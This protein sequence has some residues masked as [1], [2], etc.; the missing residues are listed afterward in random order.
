MRQKGQHGKALFQS[1]VSTPQS[2]V[3]YLVPCPQS[4]RILYTKF[5]PPLELGKYMFWSLVPNPQ[6]LISSLV[7]SLVPCLTHLRIHFGEH[8]GS[9][10]GTRSVELVSVFLPSSTSTSTTTST[11]VETSWDCTGLSSAQTGTG[12]LLYFF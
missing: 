10:Q 7:C 9:I 4:W 2:L 12:T 11:K 1:L 6:F 5:Q 8:A 3:Q